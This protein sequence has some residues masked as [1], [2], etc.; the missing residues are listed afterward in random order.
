MLELQEPEG[1]AFFSI[2]TGETFYA[3]LEPTIAALINSSDM[4]INAS[5]GQDFGWRLAPKW[6]KKVRAF[7]ADED[8]MDALAAKLR[9]E[10]G[11]S[12]STTQILYYIYGREVRQYLQTLQEHENPFEQQYQ[13]EVSGK[14]LYDMPTHLAAA[15][16][17]DEITEDVSEAD[18]MPAEEE[19]VQEPA[20]TTK[21]K[22]K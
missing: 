1:I 11:Q 6:V 5:R 17:P 9:L 14:K 22:Q 19:P 16:E 3:K 20:K 7:R 4:G 10:D 2:K 21:Q 15:M 12:P 13:E 8:K 18:L